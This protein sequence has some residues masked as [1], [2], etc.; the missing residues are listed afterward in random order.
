[1]PQVL[2]RVLSTWNADPGSRTHYGDYRVITDAEREC[3]VP[4]AGSVISAAASTR[5]VSMSVAMARAA[6]CRAVWV[7]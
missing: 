2:L 1:M 7:W 5:N 4:C 6:S 3:S